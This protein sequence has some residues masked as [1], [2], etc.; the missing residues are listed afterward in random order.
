M[1]RLLSFAVATALTVAPASLIAAPPTT[2]VFFTEWSA[3]IDEAARDAID[4]VAKLAK[5]DGAR[6]ITVTGYADTTG[7]KEANALL[8]ATR[9]QVVVDQLVADG[10]PASRIHQVVNGATNYVQTPLESRR[11]VISVAGP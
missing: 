2:V 3:L 10:V 11:V 6:D 1:S 5:Q 7:S 4:Q 8:S 9:A